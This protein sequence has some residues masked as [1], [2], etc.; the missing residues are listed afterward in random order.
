MALVADAS[1]I[2]GLDELNVIGH[3]ASGGVAPVSRPHVMVGG[4]RLLASAAS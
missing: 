1:Q 2:Q 3:I 4:E